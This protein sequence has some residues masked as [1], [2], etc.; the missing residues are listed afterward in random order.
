MGSPAYDIAKYLADNGV[1]TLPSDVKWSMNF[2]SE[3]AKP[4][5]AI[6]VYDTGGSQPTLYEEQLRDPTV[7]IRVRGFSESE[8][9]AKHNEIFELLNNVKNGIIEGRVYLG[10]WLMSDIISLGRDS[11][12]RLITTANYQIKRG[13]AQ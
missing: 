5:E 9:S 13:P 10:V 11:E 1:A 12:D 2:A 3:P 4:D 8:V 7:Q 6:T